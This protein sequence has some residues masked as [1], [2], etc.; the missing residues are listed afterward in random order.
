MDLDAFL[1]RL[2]GVMRTYGGK[3]KAT[4]PAH[5]DHVQSLEVWDADDHIG[6]NC[7]ANCTRREVVEAL[8]MWERDLYYETETVLYQQV[9][10]AVYPYHDENG[11]LLY[12]V[13][14]FPGK[15]IRPRRPDGS[16]GLNGVRR[17]LYNL[18]RLVAER[19]AADEW[20]STVYLV[21]G[22]KDADRLRDEGYVATT[23]PLG[24]GGW[25]ASYVKY[26]L[27]LRVVIVADRDIPKSDGSTAGLDHAREIA[28]SLEGI[29]E[30]VK[31]VQARA[32]KDTSD[33]L[34]AG[35]TL[36]ELEPV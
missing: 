10:E 27:G 15:Q 16:W 36:A 4:C 1:E 8:G 7:Y 2:D 3:Y 24:A 22:E 29:A 12:E 35:F 14:R 32:G 26:F 31:I 13:V 21:E 34:D 30:S 5:T 20:K 9:P 11:V 6:V 19:Y 23:S 18:P 17:V 25:K 28:E 33:H